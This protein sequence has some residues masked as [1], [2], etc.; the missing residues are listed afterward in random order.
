M[1]VANLLLKKQGARNDLNALHK[2]IKEGYSDIEIIDIDSNNM[3]HLEM[4]DKVRQKIKF[5]EFKNVFRTLDVTY[6]FGATGTGKT[7]SIM[8]QYGY[9]NVFRVTDYKNPFD[10]YKGQDVILLKNLEAL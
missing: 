8:E 1:K 6:C 10:G 3:K 9:S 5:E 4:I 2:Y 7:R